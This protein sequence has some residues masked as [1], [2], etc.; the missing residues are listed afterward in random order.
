MSSVTSATSATYAYHSISTFG[1]LKK[2]NK[3]FL[4]KCNIKVGFDSFPGSRGTLWA[5]QGQ[6]VP[7]TLWSPGIK[8]K[9]YDLTQIIQ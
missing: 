5:R 2:E 4:P 3:I 1:P 6:G 8:G 7:E 9:M